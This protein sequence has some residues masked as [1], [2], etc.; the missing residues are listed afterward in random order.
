MCVAFLLSSSI[1]KG[2]QLNQGIE[3]S[4]VHIDHHASHH[5]RTSNPLRLKPRWNHGP[6]S[7]SNPIGQGLGLPI[8]GNS[9]IIV[10]GYELFEALLG[11][12]L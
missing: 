2:L 12:L 5:D 1:Q 7:D 3:L 8:V 6:R 10:I 11:P 4:I 9:D